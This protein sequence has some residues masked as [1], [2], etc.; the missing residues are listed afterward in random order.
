MN[1]ELI[2]GA[3]NL[4]DHLNFGPSVE[5]HDSIETMDFTARDPAVAEAARIL[6]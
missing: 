3:E 1:S 4:Q 2:P 6:Y 5:V